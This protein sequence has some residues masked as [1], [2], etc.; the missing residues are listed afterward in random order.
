MDEEPTVTAH[1]SRMRWAAQCFQAP[2]IVATQVQ[3]PTVMDA[4]VQAAGAAIDD[5]ALQSSVEATINKMM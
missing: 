4:A 3:P 1:N 2:D 5:T